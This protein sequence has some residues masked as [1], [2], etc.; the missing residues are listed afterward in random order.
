MPDAGN[1]PTTAEQLRMRR[2]S[3]V[4]RFAELVFKASGVQEHALKGR[5]G[6]GGSITLLLT[7]RGKPGLATAERREKQMSPS[8][9]TLLSMGLATKVAFS[10][11][12]AAVFILNRPLTLACAWQTRYNRAVQVPASARVTALLSRASIA[13]QTV[14]GAN[15]QSAGPRSFFGICIHFR[16][17]KKKNQLTHQTQRI[18]FLE[19]GWHC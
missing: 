3:S 4:Q 14:R 15:E 7:I 8:P 5:T 12:L 17:Q 18:S 6:D 16:R 13:W 10:T 11:T 2:V 19:G 1:P 9:A